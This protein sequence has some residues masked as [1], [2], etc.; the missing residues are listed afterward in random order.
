MRAAFYILVY[1]LTFHF[2]HAEAFRG[3]LFSATTVSAPATGG[4]ALFIGRAAGR[5]F[6]DRPAH[7]PAFPKATTS[8]MRGTDVQMIRA[9]IQ[10]AESRRDGYDA[11]QFGATI[12]PRQKPT[13]M[14]LAEIYAW[15]DVTPGQPHAIGRYQFIPKTLRRVAEKTGAKPTE[16]FN[17]IGDTVARICAD[18]MAKFPIFIRPT[19]AGCLAQGIMPIYAIRSIAS[20]YVFSRQVAAGK[21]PFKYVE[22][23]WD[24]L[25]ALLGTEAFLTNRQLWGDLPE[26]YP[27]FA[28]TL[29]REIKELESKW[30]V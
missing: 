20:W 9:L 18:G 14:T 4:S 11:V 2:A 19:L 22:P 1:L 29:G 7:I 10:E 16:R 30:L 17:A 26:T 27:E 3:S 28:T 5:L 6:A 15:I 13:Q 12:K 8:G 25:K 24:D 23:S 21:I